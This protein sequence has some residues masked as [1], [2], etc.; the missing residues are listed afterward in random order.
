MSRNVTSPPWIGCWSIVGLPPA[1]HLPSP[2]LTNV[3]F[4]VASFFPIYYYYSCL[5]APSKNAHDSQFYPPKSMFMVF[6]SF[7]INPRLLTGSLD[8]ANPICQPQKILEILS[9][10]VKFWGRS[11]RNLSSLQGLENI[12]S[13]NFVSVVHNCCL[14][15]LPTYLLAYTTDKHN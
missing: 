6:V 9:S 4:V 2:R 8:Q 11:M 3:K 15:F 1:R 13:F 12:C 10:H 7:C 14:S 5:I